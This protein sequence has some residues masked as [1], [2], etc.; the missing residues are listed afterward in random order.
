M[1]L[2]PAEFLDEVINRREM[3][4]RHVGIAFNL[5]PDL[6]LDEARFLKLL[7]CT[8]AR[9]FWKRKKLSEL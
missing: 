2:G 6:D 3:D 9:A 5:D 1:E 4:P 8:I 7:G